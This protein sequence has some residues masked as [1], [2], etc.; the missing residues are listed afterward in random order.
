MTEAGSWGG[1]VASERQ[2]RDPPCSSPV[3]PG[4][5]EDVGVSLSD[6]ICKVEISKANRTR[7][8]DKMAEGP[9]A[10]F[11]AKCEQRKHDHD[12]PYLGGQS[13]GPR[14]REHRQCLAAVTG[15]LHHPNIWASH[16]LKAVSA[17]SCPALR[18]AS[19]LSSLRKL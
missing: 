13:H 11:S 19:S 6:L 17:N 18:T 12:D 5:A 3:A 4:V 10:S 7:P 8:L 14:G 15:G 2:T 1:K 16:L 9:N